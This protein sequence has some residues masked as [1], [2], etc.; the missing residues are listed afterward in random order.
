MTDQRWICVRAV[1]VLVV[2]FTA[3]LGAPLSGQDIVDGDARWSFVGDLNDF[4]ADPGADQLFQKLWFWRAAGDPSETELDFSQAA[5]TFQGNIANHDFALPG[6]SI[7]V[8]TLVVDQGAGG[9][10]TVVQSL[11]FTNPSPQPLSLDVF[12]YVDFDM[13][14]AD[15]DTATW[16]NTGSSLMV[17]DGATQNNVVVDA[18][19][20]D[21]HEIAPFPGV[22]AELRDNSVTQLANTGMPFGPGNFT[23]AFQWSFVVAPNTT[24]LFIGVLYH[25][26][27]DVPTPF[28]GFRRGDANGDGTVNLADA[29]AILTRLFLPGSPLPCADAQDVNDSGSLDLADAVTLLGNLFGMTNPPI[30]APGV[31]SCGDDPTADSLDC[32]DYTTC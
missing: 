8:E 4:E 11:T 18:L 22:R 15:G 27:G 24:Q 25:L 19:S 12:L 16:I 1:S 23:G 14:G 29:I 28:P 26:A 21:F 10:A 3:L 17:T 31:G 7:S 20:A 2:V 5:S 32:L 13:N 9:L 30:P 6:F